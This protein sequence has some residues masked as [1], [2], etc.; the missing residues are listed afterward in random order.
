M[1]RFRLYPFLII[2][3]LLSCDFGDETSQTKSNNY[4]SMIA[5][6]SIEELSAD[7]ILGIYLMREE[8]KLARDVYSAFYSLT[9]QRVF[10]N[11]AKSEQSHMDAVK[12]LID[13]YELIDPI[14]ADISGQFVDPR[15][16]T[17]YNDLLQQGS[18]LNSTLAIGAEIEEIDIIDLQTQL[19]SVINNED[20]R[21]IYTNLR[22]ASY[23]HLNAFVKNLK[24]KGITYTP[25]HLSLEAYTEIINN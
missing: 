4:E 10:S 15:L 8:E 12:V 16:Q 24:N 17:L 14:T 2:L 20:I 3:I 13:R 7:E 9:K 22:N 1:K 23:N 5:T 11:I 21:V 6:L 25:R 18:N 19:D